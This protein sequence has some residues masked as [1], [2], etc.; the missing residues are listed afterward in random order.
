MT[1]HTSQKKYIE[2]AQCMLDIFITHG[3]D[4]KTPTELIDG[5]TYPVPLKALLQVCKE[6]HTLP[7]SEHYEVFGLN[8]FQ[9]GHFLN[10]MD[11]LAG[12]DEETMDEWRSE[13]DQPNCAQDG[14]ECFAALSEFDYLF[15]NVDPTSTYFGSTRRVV[16]NCFEDEPM[17]DTFDEFF[18]RLEAFSRQWNECMETC[19][20]EDDFCAK[21]EGLVY[22]VL[23]N[24]V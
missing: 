23:F 8:M 21:H 4:C 15:V 12:G 7:A 11:I 17:T 2:R 18:G 10:K 6:W 20:W 16:N 9:D 24:H 1:G 14:W 22:N 19:V 13:H 5:A 3:G